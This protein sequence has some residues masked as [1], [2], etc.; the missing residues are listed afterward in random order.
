MPTGNK[1]RDKS[2]DLNYLQYKQYASSKKSDRC[3]EKKEEIQNNTPL[4]DFFSN[5]NET[6]K[7]KIP[8]SK[9]ITPNL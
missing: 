4:V 8:N 3:N 9:R 6:M 2:R 5:N 1:L 7:R